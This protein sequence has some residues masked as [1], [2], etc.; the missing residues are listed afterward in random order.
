MTSFQSGIRALAAAFAISVALH[1]QTLNTI[2]NFAP[3]KSGYHPAGSLIVA[4]NGNLYGVTLNGGTSGLGAVYQLVPPATSGGP[5]TEQAAGNN[6]SG[7]G[8][9]RTGTRPD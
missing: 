6:S 7:P 2:Y 4:D 1:G 5:W 3:G 8:P 9:N